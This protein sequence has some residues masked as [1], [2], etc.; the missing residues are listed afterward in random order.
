MAY[1]LALGAV[2]PFVGSLSDLMGRRYVAILGAS[3]IIIGVTVSSTAHDMNVFIGE[4]NRSAEKRGAMA[5]G[6]LQLAWQYRAPELVSMNSQLL[7]WRPNLHPPESAEPMSQP[8]S[9]QSYRSAHQSY[10]HN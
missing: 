3:L 7:L 2:C 6:L 10:G 4:R 8:S 1:L 9:S 5:H